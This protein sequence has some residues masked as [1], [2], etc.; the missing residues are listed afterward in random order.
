ME[1]GEGCGIASEYGLSKD[2]LWG[3][4]RR[5]R[6]VQPQEAVVAPARAVRA[7]NPRVTLEGS[8]GTAISKI[9]TESDADKLTNDDLLSGWKLDASEWEIVDGTVGVNRWMTSSLDHDTGEWVEHWNYQYKARV[10]RISG[11]SAPLRHAPPVVVKVNTPSRVPRRAVTD[12]RVAVLWM[13]AQI[14]Y[15]QDPVDGVWHTI[16]DE[17][18]LDIA[19]QVAIDLEAEHG[20]DEQVDV[21]DLFDLPMFSK[22]RSAPSLVSPAAFQ[23]AIDRVAVLLAE[24]RAISPNSRCRWIRG[25]H[26][27]RITNYLIDTG[28]PLLG[29]RRAGETTPLLSLDSLVN[30]SSQG[31]EYVAAPYPAGAVWL[32]HNTV[33]RHGEFAGD[34]AARKYL[35]N[36]VNTCAGHTP[37]IQL[38]HRT[39][40]RIGDNGRS[41]TRTFASAVGGGFMRVD[42]R[43]PPGRFSGVDDSGR[44][45]EAALPWQQGF[46]V[47]TYSEDGHMVPRFEYVIITSGRADFRGRVYL[48]RVDADGN[49][50]DGTT[51]RPIP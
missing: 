37:R 25:N 28:S 46:W 22:H 8:D 50:L 45:G 17:G 21:G 26:E 34:D 27:A 20:I 43:V 16:H 18:A 35:R 40:P 33:V 10:R 13:D 9:Y 14:G 49:T 12:Q 30:A 51:T 11:D 31:W 3:W 4:W 6:S 32:N 38:A 24:R 48:A 41:A 39:V 36:E 23:K 42:N 19:L 2:A 44:P 7:E 29:V 15:W 1:A 47:A 5:Q